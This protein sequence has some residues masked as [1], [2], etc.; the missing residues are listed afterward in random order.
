MSWPEDS[1]LRSMH[2]PLEEWFRFGAVSLTRIGLHRYIEERSRARK[3]LL[4]KCRRD[5][6]SRQAAKRQG[7]LEQA[8]N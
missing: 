1:H 8:Y 5:E 2:V 3:R 7:K 4:N 6:E